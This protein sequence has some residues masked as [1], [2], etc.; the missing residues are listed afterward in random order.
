MSSSRRRDSDRR[1]RRASAP[2]HETRGQELARLDAADD[3]PTGASPGTSRPARCKGDSGLKR[4]V[5]E[6][7]L[8][9]DRSSTRLRR[10]R[11]HH[12]HEHD[13]GTEGA[14]AQHRRSTT[15][16]QPEL[17]DHE[18]RQRQAETM[19]S[20]VMASEA[21]QSSSWPLSRKIWRAPMPSARSRCRPVDAPR[22]AC[23]I[24]RIVN[25]ALDHHERD[26]ADRMLM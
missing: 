25:E 18:G 12:G 4:R 26:H 19:A 6:Q 11:S 3:H 13:T 21:N 17:M 7:R 5:A 16:R 1:A 24:R 2:N 15:G 9:E 10:A 22:A 8:Q 20:I 14:H 23:E